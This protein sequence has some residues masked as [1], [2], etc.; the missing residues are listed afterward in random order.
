MGRLE[1][2]VALISGG[3]RGMGAVEAEMFANEGA[4]VVIAD[5]LENEGRKTAPK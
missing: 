5:I 1:N 3:S 2:K 4:H